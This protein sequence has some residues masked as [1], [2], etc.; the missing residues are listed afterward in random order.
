[1]AR[2]GSRNPAVVSARS[3]AHQGILQI[4]A[5]LD[6]YGTNDSVVPSLRYQYS[7][8]YMDLRSLDSGFSPIVEL[9]GGILGGG[10]SDKAGAAIGGSGSAVGFAA[11]YLAGAVTTI[12]SMEQTRSS[13]RAKLKGL[14]EVA[15]PLAKDQ[16]QARRR[17][18]GIANLERQ[19]AT[20]DAQHASN[21]YEFQQARILS[22][23]FWKDLTILMRRILH[24]Y[25]ELGGRATLEG[26]VTVS[27][28]ELEGTDSL[29]QRSVGSNFAAFDA[30][31]RVPERTLDVLKGAPLGASL[32]LTVALAETAAPEEVADIIVGIELG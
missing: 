19:S 3:R 13:M 30:A 7:A 28:G 9:F 23:D 27:V 26:N 10:T 22:T 14:K 1:M 2:A 16:L 21:L 11:A 6:A 32:S 17:E 31:S 24:R 20:L 29:E 8:V 12:E 18:V 15:I 25:L 5:G 4:D